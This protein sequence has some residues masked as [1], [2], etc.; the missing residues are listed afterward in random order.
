MQA[1]ILA[2]GEGKR[3]RETTSVPKCMIPMGGV[4]LLHRHLGALQ[5]V[6]VDEAVLVVGYRAEQVIAHAGEFPL[7]CRFVKNEIFSKTNTAYSLWL[8]RASLNDDFLYL[9]ADVLFHPDI[10]HRLVNSGR[11]SA[12]AIVSKPCGAEEV[13]VR[14]LQ[15]RVTQI[16]KHIEPSTCAGEFIGIARFVKHDWIALQS[17]LGQLVNAENRANE[18]FEVAVDRLLPE[19]VVTAVDV[20]DLPCIEID[21]PEDLVQARGRVLPLMPDCGIPECDAS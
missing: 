12:M 5:G 11:R 9:N 17:A 7:K 13:K 18:Y 3:L 2:A 20:S 10:V 19:T 16:G 4:S 14:L 1:V 8:A 21:S 15:G 6:G